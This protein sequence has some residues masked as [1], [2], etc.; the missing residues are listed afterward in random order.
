[1][2]FWA[3]VETGPMRPYGAQGCHKGPSS[4][5]R[6]LQMPEPART[7]EGPALQ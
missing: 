4:M 5:L 6:M 7:V 1:M 2:T 3:Q